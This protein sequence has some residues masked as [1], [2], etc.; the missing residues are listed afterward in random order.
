[1]RFTTKLLPSR[2]GNLGVVTLNNPKAL[3][4]LTQDMIDCF[5]DVLNQWTK[6]KDAGGETLKGIL[7][8]GNAEAKRP[9]FCAGGDVKAVYDNGLSN[10]NPQDFFFQEYRVN[11]AIATTKIPVISLWDG[12]VMGGGCGISVHGKY[13]VATENS[14]M[15]MPETAIGLFPDVG[16]MW[17]MNRLLSRP[18]ANYLALSGARITA[19][20]LIHTGLATH[21][22][23][24][25]QLPDLEHA[26]VEASE[27]TD[28]DGVDALAGVLMS[29]HERIPTDD[30]LL[31][32]H[33]EEIEQA[34]QAESVE[35][36]VSNLEQ[37]SSQFAIKTMDALRKM[38]PTSMKVTFEGLNRGAKCAS[39]GEDLQMEFRMAKA[40]VRPGADFYEG[41]RAVLV[42]KDH[43]PKW[44]PAT[45]EEVTDEMVEEFFAPIDM[46][47]MLGSKL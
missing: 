18:V 25:K 13:R 12:V 2:S 29:F 44:N 7:I 14:L 20:D 41:V 19:A 45:L 34:F 46:E 6:G 9:A 5:Q 22:V 35:A 28:N 42:D 15:A 33:K 23:P 8:K 31:V 32:Q 24:S 16:S 3:H 4:A 39:V 47:L 27:Q 36:I 1:M 11:H 37:S 21:Y 30:C 17:W 43:S 10:N 40:C 38:S 26:L